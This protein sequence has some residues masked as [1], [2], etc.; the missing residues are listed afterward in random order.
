MAPGSRAFAADATDPAVSAS[1]QAEGMHQDDEQLLRRR[2]H[3]RRAGGRR[4]RSP[5]GAGPNWS[6]AR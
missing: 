4:G 3:G 2:M 5:A 6:A 1:D